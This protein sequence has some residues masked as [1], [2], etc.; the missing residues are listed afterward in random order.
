MTLG[1]AAKGKNEF[2]TDHHN[3]PHQ[4]KPY[5]RPRQ[6]DVAAVRTMV[7]SFEALQ[8]P[9]GSGEVAR[10]RVVEWY[11][12]HRMIL[13]LVLPCPCEPIGEIN[14]DTA[15]WAASCGAVACA[16]VRARLQ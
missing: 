11:D 1:H 15:T 16:A 5:H 10:A 4:E 14:A 8:T 7:S 2:C 13:A 9:F 6:M 12:A 3:A